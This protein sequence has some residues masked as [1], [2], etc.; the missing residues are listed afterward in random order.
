M[1]RPY[2]I[3]SRC[4]MDTSDPEIRFDAAGVCH[5]CRQY[6]HLVALSLPEPAAA[7]DRLSRLVARMKRD[8]GGK[9]YD[10][11]LGVSGGVDSSYAAV[12]VRELGLRALAVHFDNGWD[13][14]LAVQNIERLV[15]ALG[16]DLTTY[17]VDWNEFRDLQLAF[18]R[19]STPDAEIPTDHAIFSLIRQVALAQ[20]VRYVVSGTNLRTE[21]HIPAAWSQGHQDWKYIRAVHARFGTLPLRTYPHRSRLQD[22]HYRL[23]TRYVEIL[24]L[25]DYVKAEAK[26]HL[27]AHYGWRDY[28]G[29]HHESI[30]TRF[31]QGYL[32]PVK[33]GFDKRRAHLSSLICSRQVSREE[34]LRI[35]EQPACPPEVQQSDREYVAKKLGLSPAQFAEIMAL[36]VKSMRDYPHYARIAGMWGYRW[37]RL[38]FR[39]LK[40]EA[41][42]R[43]RRSRRRAGV[44]WRPQA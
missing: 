29:K 9:E 15:T 25:L 8:G 21:T 1:S 13:S 33:F 35:L 2:G 27:E 10:C 38:A 23:R 11:V 37:A 24:N 3:C 7:R 43:V 31:C 28:G 22:R 18:L 36:P 26:A 40:Y 30:Y 42:P 39:F 20:K 34:A 44:S 16:M 6:D 32:F 17:V 5:H 14:E 41:L 4:V 19:A 12:K